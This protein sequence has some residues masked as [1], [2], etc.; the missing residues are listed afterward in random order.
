MQIENNKVVAFNYT[1]A[2]LDG[3]EIEASEEKE[4]MLYLHG[5]QQLLEALQEGLAGHRAGEQVVVDVPPERA[6]GL[7]RDNSAHRIPLKHVVGYAEPRKSSGKKSHTAKLHTGQVIRVNT[8]QGERDATV[9][10]LGKFNVDIDTNHPLAGKHLRFTVD[11]VDVRDAT[12]EELAH[13][14][15]HG[16]GGHQH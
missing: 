6:Y 11:I 7:R 12:D 14:H 13:G 1:L 2:E 5:T 8:P 4:P 10:K 15:P 3:D 16:P 9:V